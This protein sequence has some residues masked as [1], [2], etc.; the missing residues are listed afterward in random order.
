MLWSEDDAKGLPVSSGVRHKLRV[1]PSKIVFSRIIIAD[2][3]VNALVQELR[4]ML[5]R[6]LAEGR[7]NVVDS[8]SI[9]DDRK[10]A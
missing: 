2:V 1:K 3:V 5:Q 10:L 6:R 4:I 7:V 9:F 8:G